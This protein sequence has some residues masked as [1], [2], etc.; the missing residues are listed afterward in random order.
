MDFTGKIIVERTRTKERASVKEQG[1][2][3]LQ[4]FNYLQISDGQKKIH[5]TPMFY[6]AHRWKGYFGIIPG[7]PLFSVMNLQLETN[8]CSQ[9]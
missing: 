7:H 5:L 4:K 1:T 8:S 3:C 2:S 6:M 9:T